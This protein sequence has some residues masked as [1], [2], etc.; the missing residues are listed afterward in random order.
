[1]SVIRGLVHPIAGPIV[2][3]VLRQSVAAEESTAFEAHGYAIIDTG[4]AL[5]GID[6]DLAIRLKLPPVGTIKLTRP[7]PSP[8]FTAARFHGEVAFPGSRFPSF[9]HT[10]VGYHNLDT[11][12]GDTIRIVAL[13]GRDWLH[14]CRLILKGAREVEIHRI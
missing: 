7:G 3:V 11:R 1:M 12:F 4:A 6:E 8:D 10:L 14:D 9:A 5:S 13:L 2:P